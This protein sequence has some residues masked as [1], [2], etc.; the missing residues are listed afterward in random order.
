MLQGFA[1]MAPEKAAKLQ[2]KAVRA[3]KKNKVGPT[4]E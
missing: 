4:E 3:R 2:K 1:A